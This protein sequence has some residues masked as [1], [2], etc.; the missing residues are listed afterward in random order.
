MGTWERGRRKQE[1]KQTKIKWPWT[2]LTRVQ[3]DGRCHTSTWTGAA[4]TSAGCCHVHATVLSPPS[5]CFAQHDHPEFPTMPTSPISGL[6]AGQNRIGTEGYKRSLKSRGYQFRY[7]STIWIY[8]ARR[9]SVREGRGTDHGTGVNT[10]QQP[11][12]TQVA[13]IQQLTLAASALL[14]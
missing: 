4:W 3:R 11:G 5:Q 14:V 13:L 2:W 9:R 10:L 12:L 7:S 6:L 8:H 1:M